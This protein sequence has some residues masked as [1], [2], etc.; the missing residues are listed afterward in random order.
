MACI[1]AKSKNLCANSQLCL[2]MM[3]RHILCFDKLGFSPAECVSGRS[4][5][6]IRKYMILIIY[7]CCSVNITQIAWFIKSSSLVGT[8][9]L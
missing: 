3:T 6:T 4:P 1:R 8:F 9:S 5:S 7:S 2:V